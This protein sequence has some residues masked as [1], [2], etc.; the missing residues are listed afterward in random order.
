MQTQVPAQ[1]V[2]SKAAITRSRLFP[3]PAPLSADASGNYWT[4]THLAASDL[5]GAGVLL[6]RPM[7]R[8][9]SSTETMLSVFFM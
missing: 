7:A 3:A 8:A 2:V 1:A 9:I 4:Q 5:A 6:P